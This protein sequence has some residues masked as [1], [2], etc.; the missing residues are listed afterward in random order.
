MKISISVIESWIE[1]DMYDV[2]NVIV[3]YLA[4]L[5]KVFYANPRKWKLFF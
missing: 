3:A 5:Y 2:Q 1:C 4:R